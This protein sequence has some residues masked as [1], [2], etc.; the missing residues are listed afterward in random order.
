M[1]IGIISDSHN[2]L[3]NL[4]RALAH[5]RA[6]G[7]ETLVHCG[8]MT[9]P[10]TARRLAG[11]RVIHATG[12]GD[13]ASGEI[14]AVLRQ[15]NPE[16]SSQ[17]VFTGQVNGWSVAVTHGH[18]KG[19]VEELAASGIFEFVFHGHTHRRRDERA[20]STRVINPGALGGLRVGPRSFCLLDLDSGEAEFIELD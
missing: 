3:E 15:L 8:D 10:E 20:G 18:L 5:L 12:N 14:A 13:Y 6:A 11:F 17:P 4:D 9:D 16:S 1:K 19:K 2:N 7:V